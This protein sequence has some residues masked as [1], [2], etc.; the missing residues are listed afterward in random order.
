MSVQYVTNDKGKRIAVLLP[1][2]QWQRI[3]EELGIYGSDDETAEILADPAFL[4]RIAKGRGQARKR[5][6][7]PLGEVKV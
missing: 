1:I 4:A 2:D 5:E 7:R 3:L 6:G